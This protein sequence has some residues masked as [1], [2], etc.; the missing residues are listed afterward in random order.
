MPLY[1]AIS[2]ELTRTFLNVLM[3]PLLPSVS[4]QGTYSSKMSLPSMAEFEAKEKE[5][6]EQQQSG[7]N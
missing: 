2:D 1:L 3:P 6:S 4:I 5:Q 7:L